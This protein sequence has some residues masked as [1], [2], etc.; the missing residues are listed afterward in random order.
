MHQVK[1]GVTGPAD[2]RVVSFALA[3]VFAAADVNRDSALETGDAVPGVK[4]EP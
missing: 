4:A 1:I 2:S 3:V